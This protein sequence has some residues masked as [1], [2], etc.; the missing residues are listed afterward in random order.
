M[1]VTLSQIADEFNLEKAWVRAKCWAQT[2]DV[3]YDAEEYD[4]FERHLTANLKIAKWLALGGY[5]PGRALGIMVPKEGGYRVLYRLA[6]WDN[7]IAMAVLNLLIPP[8]EQIVSDKS[9]G[10]SFGN[11]FHVGDTKQVLVEWRDQHASFAAAVRSFGSL[12]D[13]Y[14]YV[15][16]D[17]S[18]YYPSINVERVLSLIAPLVDEA[19]YELI[20]GFLRMEGRVGRDQP[21]MIDGLPIGAAHSALFANLYLADLDEWMLSHTA[22][23]ARYVDDFFYAAPSGEEV[24]ALSLQASQ[25]LSEIGLAAHPEKTERYPVTDTA[26]IDRT[27]T[28]L[29]YDLRIETSELQV[30]GLQ[31]QAQSLLYE[32]F[33][34]SEYYEHPRTTAFLAWRLREM[35]Y[36]DVDALTDM[37]CRVI[38]A[39]GL[40]VAQIRRLL[41]FILENNPSQLPVRLV[42]YLRCTDDI[43]SRLIALDLL[44]EFPGCAAS[45][46]PG[47][48]AAFTQSSSFLVRAYAY[49]TLGPLA[50]QDID[51]DVLRANY[52]GE[53]STLVKAKI[54]ALMAKRFP[55]QAASALPRWVRESSEVREAALHSVRALEP[56]VAKATVAAV[57]VEQVEGAE[58]SIYVYLLLRHSLGSIL[59]T[60]LESQTIVP[61]THDRDGTLVALATDVFADCLSESDHLGCLGVVL[62]IASLD[63]DLAATSIYR[64]QHQLQALPAGL[65]ERFAAQLGQVIPEVASKATVWSLQQDDSPRLVFLDSYRIRKV[66]SEVTPASS[67]LYEV[68]CLDTNRDGILEIIGLPRLEAHGVSSAQFHAILDRLSRDGIST[69]IVKGDIE[70]ASGLPCTWAVYLYPGNAIPLQQHIE[71]TSDTATLTD[72]I[73]VVGDVAEKVRQSGVAERMQSIHGRMVVIDNDLRT[74][75]CAMGTSIVETLYRYTF[76]TEC[77]SDGLGSANLSFCF[78]ILLYEYISGESAYHDLQLTKREQGSLR[79]KVTVA[80]PESAGVPHLAYIINR[81]TAALRGHRYSDIRPLTEDLAHVRKYLLNFESLGLGQPG[82]ATWPLVLADY[83]EFRFEIVLRSPGAIRS[84]TPMQLRRHLYGELVQ[85]LLS[86]LARHPEGSKPADLGIAYDIRTSSPAAEQLVKLAGRLWYLIAEANS[87]FG[88]EYPFRV[89]VLVLARLLDFESAATAYSLVSDLSSRSAEVEVCASALS[90]WAGSAGSGDAWVGPLDEPQKRVSLDVGQD[91]GSRLARIMASAGSPQ[92]VVSQLGDSVDVA[93]LAALRT[94]GIHAGAGSTSFAFEHLSL[95]P[96]IGNHCALE[97]LLVASALEPVLARLFVDKA[98]EDAQLLL[99]NRMVPALRGL[100]RIRRGRRHRGRVL[101]YDRICEQQGE[102]EWR[103]F[104]FARRACAWRM[105]EVV[106]IGLEPLSTDREMHAS[107]DISETG[108]TVLAVMTPVSR[109]SLLAFDNPW[110]RARLRFS[111]HR[112]R[113]LLAASALVMSALLLVS[114]MIPYGILALVV[115]LLLLLFEQLVS[116]AR[117]AMVD[118]FTSR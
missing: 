15:R 64:L 40:S 105:N 53:I 86:L 108:T 84:T 101:K 21:G 98:P 87:K 72:K 27:I 66:L 57:P 14:W 13:G 48:L 79:D 44:S 8:V 60:Y 2:F 80:L 61:D 88:A 92:Q 11:R 93:L 34:D 52:L 74:Y 82:M 90:S 112:L 91:R 39:G 20:V 56:G 51:V 70:L 30:S 78:G 102:F 68:E 42:E 16:S 5:E 117:Q 1:T 43:A 94:R 29:K 111:E 33:V 103:R 73:A 17:I 32:A 58:L 77:R 113:Y 107:I 99:R 19:T 38:E 12:P 97:L 85:E 28:R 49:Q 69:D 46:P 3:F 106:H 116:L 22:H 55:E 37:V 41:T 83:G 7:V 118:R 67:G 59:T 96:P 4:R 45:L 71:C 100:H 104:L 110:V 54:V 18:D 62:V 23:Y 47:M 109:L 115:A 89:P 25:R 9:S 6:V 35:G 81:A 31:D 95:V 75:L 26:C 24:V 63:P 50:S 114:R 76:S 10:R 65:A 36:A